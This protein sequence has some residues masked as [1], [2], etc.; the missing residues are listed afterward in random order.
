MDAGLKL[1]EPWFRPE[2]KRG[3]S[4]VT[5]ARAEISADHEL[6][7]RALTAVAACSGCDDVAFR[8]D[9]DTFALVHLTWTHRLEPKP[10]PVTQRLSDLQAL[11]RAFDKHQ[12]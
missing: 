10:W 7:G 6:A 12:H 9:D 5:E 3:A 1:S 8:L 4:L 2:P 11:K